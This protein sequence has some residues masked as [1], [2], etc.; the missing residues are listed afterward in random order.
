MGME[1]HARGT[2]IESG[3]DR[4]TGVSASLV[5]PAVLEK[6]RLEV[7][8]DHG[9]CRA[10][11]RHFSTNLPRRIEQLRLALTT[12]DLAGSMVAARNLKTSSHN[13]GAERLASMAQDLEQSLN[14]ETSRTNSDYALP[15]LAA[16][17]LRR[18]KTCAEQTDSILQ[19]T[20]RVSNP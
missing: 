13:L 17:Q 12:G 19:R 8:N 2:R 1:L 5:D 7:N 10:L 15:R 20:L 11:A 3:I 4:A 9:V 14:K 18:I 16:T 6:L